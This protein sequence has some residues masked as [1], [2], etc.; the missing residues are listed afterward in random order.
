MALHLSLLRKFTK[1]LM[2][3]YSNILIL[4]KLGIFINEWYSTWM[5][6]LSILISTKQI[7]LRKIGNHL[8]FILDGNLNR[9][10]K[11]PTRSPHTLEV[12][13]LNL[14]I[15]RNILSPGIL[16]S[17]FPGGMNLL[18]LIL[19]LLMHLPSMMEVPW[20]NDTLVCGANGIK[21]QKQFINTPYDNIKTRGAMDTIITDGGKYDDTILPVISLF[22]L[23]SNNSTM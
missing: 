10:S 20:H 14:I 6:Q 11:P 22:S 19:S 2:T 8:V 12:L 4:M 17:T 13:S 5:F 1:K 7:L 3:L 9:L 16:F 18:L 21:S 23:R 15:S